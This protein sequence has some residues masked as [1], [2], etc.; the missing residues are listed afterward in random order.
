MVFEDTLRL[1]QPKQV[2]SPTPVEMAMS[3][4]C[5][6]EAVIHT[7]LYTVFRSVRQFILLKTDNFLSILNPLFLQ[8][9][10]GVLI[11]HYGAS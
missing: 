11:F 5:V 6:L 3:L 1:K 8:A 2:H 9:L 4:V 7:T 10:Q